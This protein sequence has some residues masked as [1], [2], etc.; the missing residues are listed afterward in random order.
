[1]ATF[2]GTTSSGGTNDVGTVFRISPSGTFKSLYSFCSQANCAD[3][4]GSSSLIQGTDG[5]FYG[6]A[7]GGGAS[8]EGTIFQLTPSGVLIKLYDFCPQVCANNPGPGGLVQH[9]DGN[10]YGLTFYDGNSTCA[11]LGCGSIFK[12]ATGLGPFVKVLAPQ[13]RWDLRQSSWE[14]I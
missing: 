12:L 3:G 8:N 10:F 5:N 4:F 2:Y 14:R 7:G 11:A 13:E 1:M 6:T 9:T